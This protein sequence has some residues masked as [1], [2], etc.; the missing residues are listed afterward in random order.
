M[1]QLRNINQPKY[2]I[3]DKVRLNGYLGTITDVWDS[4][5][6]YRY[7]VTLHWKKQV[8]SAAEKEISK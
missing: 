2:T 8:W 4:G 6:G 7:Y 1:T 5:H 3:G